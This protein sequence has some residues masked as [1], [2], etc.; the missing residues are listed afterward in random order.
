MAK[1]KKAIKI[2]T[3]ASMSKKY[4][5]SGYG[6]KVLEAP[7]LWLPCKFLAVN[8]QF[9]GGIPYGKILE[10]F[11]TESGGKTLLAQDFAYACQQLGGMV[12]WADAEKSFTK[13]WAEKNGL[14]MDKIWL[15]KENTIENISDWVRDSIYM[16]RSQLVNNEPILLVVDSLAALECEANQN[17]EQLDRKAEMGNRAKAIGTF[18]RGRN[19][20]LDELGICTILVNQLRSKVGASKFE[21]PDTTPGGEATKFFADIR[22]GVYGGKQIVKKIKGKETRVG[23]LSSIR[24]KKNKVAPPRDTIKGAE[25]YFNAEYK[26][27]PI[28][29]NRYFGLEEIILEKEILLK[30]G[31]KYSFR[32]K[33]IATKK[34]GIMEALMENE[35]LRRKIIRK[36]GINSIGTLQKKL[37]SIETNLF[38]VSIKKDKDEEKDEE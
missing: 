35:D 9:G 3:M 26:K 28:G 17:T 37:D 5:G 11:G 13:E 16:W 33:V 15:Y 18:L 29:F 23:R 19:P 27:M 30:Q 31:N 34:D 36:L 8:Y 10:L 32:G 22:A 24:I 21:D 25:V 2:P 12:I 1:A 38:P 14:D 20:L 7:M 6:T 4:G